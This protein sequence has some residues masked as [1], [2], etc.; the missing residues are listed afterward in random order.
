MEN[1]NFISDVNCKF[2]EKQSDIERLINDSN[3]LQNLIGLYNKLFEL[4]DNSVYE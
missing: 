3:Y 2:Q 1:R 4:S